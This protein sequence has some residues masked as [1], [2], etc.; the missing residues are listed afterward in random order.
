MTESNN[1]WVK[2]VKEKNLKN[3]NLRDYKV[4]YSDLPYGKVY[5]QKERSLEKVHVRK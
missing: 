4:K 1:I 5:Y 2:L 3:N